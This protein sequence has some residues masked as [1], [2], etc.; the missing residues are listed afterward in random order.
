MAIDRG[1]GLRAVGQNRQ[2]SGQ[3]LGARARYQVW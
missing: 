3:T 1:Q 2:V